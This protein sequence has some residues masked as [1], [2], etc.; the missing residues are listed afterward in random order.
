MRR[1]LI[2]LSIFF[3]F[4][5]NLVAMEKK[6]YHHVYENEKFKEFRNLP[7]DVPKWGKRKWPYFKWTKLK[8]E[9]DTFVPDEFLLSKDEKVR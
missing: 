3:F 9:I 7:A 1:P 6:P 5:S 8:K 2:I 4:N